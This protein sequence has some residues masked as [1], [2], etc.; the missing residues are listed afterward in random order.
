[1]MATAAL[2]GR[3]KL[4]LVV[5]PLLEPFGLWVEQLVAEST[6][7]QGVGIVPV[8]GETLGTPEVYG[9][10]RMFVRLR[11]EHDEDEAR[12]DRAMA[13]LAA[14]PAAT[15]SFAEPAALGAEFAR[16]EIAT[17]VAGVLLGINPFDE[18]NVQQAKDATGVLLNKFKSEGRLPAGT[19]DLTRDG[20]AFSLTTAARTAL[21][22]KPPASFATLLGAGDYLA[23]LAYLGPDPDLGDRLRHFRL[24]VRDLAR[25]ATMEGYGPRYLHSTGQLH[26]GGPNS[27]VFVLVS[28]TPVADVDIPG[29]PFSFGT[30]E[31]AQALGD[32]ASLEATG[33][34]GLHI[35]LPSPD[36]RQLG[37]ALDLLLT[38]LR[39]TSA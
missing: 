14:A 12:R 31:L 20:I 29:Q 33:R 22:G 36:G 39:Q 15:I 26:K 17:A 38:P 7:K 13:R 10:D 34:R 24:S 37:A 4:T 35:H 3:D 30:L 32:F 27:G 11:L 21:A 18:P 5:P 1:M 19:P 23:L 6:G 9:D 2:A 8:A 16:W 28:A 25:T